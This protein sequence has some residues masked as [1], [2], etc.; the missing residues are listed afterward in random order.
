[1]NLLGGCKSMTNLFPFL[2]CQFILF[3]F[4]WNNIFCFYFFISLFYFF[5][6]LF[7]CLAAFRAGSPSMT[8][9]IRLSS[10]FVAELAVRLWGYL[11]YGKLNSLYYVWATEKMVVFSGWSCWDGFN[12]CPI[13]GSHC[14]PR[15]VQVVRSA[16]RPFIAPC[17]FSYFH[18]GLYLSCFWYPSRNFALV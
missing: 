2:S 5:Y 8:Y 12:S 16:K 1:M 15:T 11:S 10:L 6:F 7:K 9:V 14:W 13:A 3:Q 17:L 4:T 18:T